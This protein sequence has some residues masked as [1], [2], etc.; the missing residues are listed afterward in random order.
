M[1]TFYENLEILRRNVPMSQMPQKRG[2]WLRI[3]HSQCN[4]V[5][6]HLCRVKILFDQLGRFVPDHHNLS[7]EC[8]LMCIV[9]FSP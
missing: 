9:Y 8:N 7:N 4:K 1:V 5:K 2:E 3:A 6:Y